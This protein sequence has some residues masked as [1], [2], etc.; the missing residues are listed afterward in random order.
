MEAVSELTSNPFLAAF[1]RFVSR[2]VC[3]SNVYS[4]NGKNFVEAAKII[5]QHFLKAAK[6]RTEEIYTMHN[7]VWHFIPPGAPH[8][9]RLWE[10]GVKGFKQH[11]IKVA[12]FKYTFDELSTLLRRIESCLNS[13]LISDV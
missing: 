10:S 7:V 13:R 2:R 6:S 4:D 11:S 8:M 5:A 12:D 1:S 9:G 3:P